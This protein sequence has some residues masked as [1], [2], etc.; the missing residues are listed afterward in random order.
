MTL[1]VKLSKVS[2]AN[3]RSMRHQTLDPCCGGWSRARSETHGLSPDHTT[4]VKLIPF[5]RRR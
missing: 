5:L 3:I 1:A 2:S 4:R